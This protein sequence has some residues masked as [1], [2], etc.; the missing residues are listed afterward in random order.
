M[1]DVLTFLSDSFDN[2]LQYRSINVLRS[3]LSVTHPKIDGY[4]VGQHP[5]VVNLLKGILNQRSPKPRNSQT[6]DASTVMSHLVKMGNNSKLSLKHLFWKLSTIFAIIYCKRVSSLA[7]LDLNHRLAPEGITF[8]LS[9]TK[10]TRPDKP[11][12]AIVPLFP[13]D[14]KLCL[15][16]CFKQYITSTATLRTTPESEPKRLFILYIKPYRAVSPSII[17]RWIR[18][19][20]AESKLV[21]TPQF[22]KHTQFEALSPSQQQMLQYLLRKS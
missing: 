17:A 5:Y 18:E 3:T 2:G 21:S 7:H 4:A 20:L 19:L 10:T 8:I 1:K 15:V 11:V 22:L 9:K 14:T 12:S 13:E 16:A 6:W